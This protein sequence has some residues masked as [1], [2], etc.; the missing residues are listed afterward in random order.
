[1]PNNLLTQEE[2]NN[3]IREPD[4][5]YQ[6]QLLE[7][8][9]ENIVFNINRIFQKECSEKYVDYVKSELGKIL[10]ASND[11]HDDVL[12]TAL[13]DY[14]KKHWEIFGQTSLSYT[15]LPNHPVT[16]LLVNLAERLSERDKAPAIGYLLPGVYTQHFT[17]E[18]QNLDN[19]DLQTVLATH[20][21]DE[22]GQYL[23][24]AKMVLDDAK[25]I[26]APTED[27]INYKTVN[28]LF[29]PYYNTSDT[30]QK[31]KFVSKPDLMRLYDYSPES[32]LLYNAYQR[33]WAAAT[34]KAT[35]LGQLN[36][37]IPVLKTN[38]AHGG[39]G[40]ETDVGE[41]AYTAIPTFIDYYRRL[42]P[43]SIQYAEGKPTSDTLDQIMGEERKLGY[44]IVTTGADAGLYCVNR[45][46]EGEKNIKKL[47][48][49]QT[50]ARYPLTLLRQRS[51]DE[52]K[53]LDHKQEGQ[54][55]LVHADDQ[56]HLY[57][58]QD[59]GTWRFVTIQIAARIRLSEQDNAPSNL[60]LGNVP[61]AIYE[62]ID[63]AKAHIE[64]K[65]MLSAL[66]EACQATITCSNEQL[67]I[68]H[69]HTGHMDLT[70]FSNVP[71]S[72]R[73]PIAD[74]WDFIQ[75]P[76]RN[77]TATETTETCIGTIR[78]HLE[79]AVQ[80]HTD[81]LDTIQWSEVD[82][83]YNLQACK[84]KLAEARRAFDQSNI[85]G[86]DF[87]LPTPQML[88]TINHPLH[89]RTDDKFEWFCHFPSDV[90]QAFFK[91]ENEDS[92]KK[93]FQQHYLDFQKFGQLLLKVPASA[94]PV[95]LDN[96]VP[97][98]S[99]S[100][101]GQLMQFM[102]DE[103]KKDALLDWRL[104]KQ[105]ENVFDFT[106]VIEYSPTPLLREIA[107]NTW[108][109]D[110]PA[111][112][113]SAGD[114][115]HV[116]GCL[117]LNDSQKEF[118]FEQVKNRLT[119]MI[120]NSRA[121]LAIIEPLNASQRNVVFDIV[122]NNVD[123]NISLILECL[124]R[125]PEL[126]ETKNGQDVIARIDDCAQLG[127]V[128][129]YF[130]ENQRD[131]LFNKI[132]ES[133]V[134]CSIFV[135]S[136]HTFVG[137]LRSLN[138]EQRG[139]VLTAVGVKRLLKLLGNEYPYYYLLGILKVLNNTQ[140]VWVL[141]DLGDNLPNIIK[142]T[143]Q[144]G[145]ILNL[146]DEP[147]KYGILLEALE[148]NLPTFF[149]DENACRNM[150]SM[151]KDESKKVAT[152]EALK[153]YLQNIIKNNDAFL[154]FFD[155]LP[156][157][158]REDFIKGLQGSLSEY[159]DTSEELGEV[160]QH[161][162][163]DRI[164][165]VL[166]TLKDKLPDIVKNGK[167]LGNVLKFISHN[168]QPECNTILEAFEERLPEIIKTSENLV[169]VLC[170]QNEGKL[171]VFNALREQVL[172]V[173]RTPYD[174]AKLINSRYIPK[175]A[176]F[177]LLG[178]K[179]P[180][181]L[182]TQQDLN[183]LNE[184]LLSSVISGTN[185]QLIKNEMNFI[186]AQWKRIPEPSQI[187]EPPPINKHEV[188]SQRTEK[189]EKMEKMEKIDEKLT[190]Y[191]E[192]RQ[193]Q[194][195]FHWDFL[196]VMA[197]VHWLVGGAWIKSKDTKIAAATYARHAH[198]NSAESLV[199][200]KEFKKEPT[201][202][203]LNQNH[204][205]TYLLIGQHAERTLYYVDYSGEKTAVGIKNMDDVIKY[206]NHSDYGRQ[207]TY[208]EIHQGLSKHIHGMLPTDAQLKALQ[209]GS[210]GEIVRQKG[211]DETILSGTKRIDETNPGPT[212]GFS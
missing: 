196:G 5:A 44:V 191:I 120:S 79:T 173:I 198:Q 26:E 124:D 55:M 137:W 203:Q 207:F 178:D 142:D 104:L 171:F 126:K 87:L 16:Q 134:P 164:S 143:Q 144:L 174:L 131:V 78:E 67:N 70:E 110:L 103:A 84:E 157:S 27:E 34:D 127:N 4:V 30:E 105:P 81:V 53:A 179:L 23:I 162:S 166:L 156:S 132:M 28:G 7:N 155:S 65:T 116:L 3:L 167:D 160:L 153:P 117:E 20:I 183:L 35:L 36:T 193:G 107:F 182:A 74:A 201:K 135:Y 96:R 184:F 130:D 114:L 158:T 57:G 25:V 62:A 190:S 150:M 119:D 129:T 50:P 24:P 111:L 139:V 138:D 11:Q 212:Q 172:R 6:D 32:R 13:I 75:N 83:K 1:M 98:L 41:A 10:V 169:E 17:E 38:D 186:R 149:Q 40:K 208:D 180:I 46:E 86:Q 72:V 189:M 101:W 147:S 99:N 205:N 121:A 108:K 123:R 80:Q 154:G 8:N 94:F 194:Y 51:F 181:I 140:C 14:L 89:I 56:Y 64:E 22:S 145:F 69:A 128:L 115:S 122:I 60:A 170:E 209:D 31:H 43:M 59:D 112:I 21:I 63:Q 45:Y 204:Q 97:P 187:H 12:K 100:N 42:N 68:I 82:K 73:I 19:Q 159:I 33:Y 175:D 192:T 88:T 2:L 146:L 185:L 141:N 148:N 151:I 71:E 199:T 76:A 168:K 161:L 54:P 61:V 136:I 200:L 91:N 125:D 37:L 113:R 49:D 176:I 177:K 202:E 90:M 77:L 58:R 52:A 18:D 93:Y 106:G 29:N 102:T 85:Q 210:L 211:L 47:C 95:L 66:I 133:K 15:A 197:F 152:F 165:S 163:N 109:G 39:F 206:F 9:Q 118:V 48:N 92:P 188:R 195:T